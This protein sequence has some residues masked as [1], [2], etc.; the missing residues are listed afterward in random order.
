MNKKEADSHWICC[1]VCG[2]K[3]RTKVYADTVLVNFPLYC[4]NC[5]R[6]FRVTVA[7]LKMILSD[8]PDA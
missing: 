4:S 6:E 5:K 2:N 7:Q 3:T 8:E 1:P